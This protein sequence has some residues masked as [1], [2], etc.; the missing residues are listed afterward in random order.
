MSDA[1]SPQQVSMRRFRGD[2]SIGQSGKAVV[3]F[4]RWSS[5]LFENVQRGIFAEYLVAIALDVADCTRIGWTGYDLLY[6][7]N[8]IEVK[9]SSYLQSWKQRT[10]SR[11]TFS[12][13]PRE[14]WDEETG[15]FSDPRYV[16]DAFV[17]CLYGHKDSRSADILDVTHWL[18]Y[19]VN[20]KSLIERFGLAKSI[21][22]SALC[23]LTSWVT[24]NALQERVDAILA[25][26]AAFI[27]QPRRQR[28]GLNG[29]ETRYTYA[30]AE[31]GTRLHPVIVTAADY[32]EAF[33]R[34]RVDERITAFGANISAIRLSAAALEAAIA[35]GARDLR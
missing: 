5:D 35:K 6:G 21:S 1:P 23:A 3:D 10:L 27:S 22:E 29:D 12:I 31:R 26:A 2:E 33:E 4:W 24:F 19:V 14:Q 13:G 11:P 18:F 30:V 28:G 32:L 16:A 25:N 34:A 7:E 9:S 8:K 15:L 20:T 17:F